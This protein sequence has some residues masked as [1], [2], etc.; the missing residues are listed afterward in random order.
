VS[1]WKKRK[2]PQRPLSGQ[3]N[4][5]EDPWT[6]HHEKVYVTL[7]VTLAGNVYSQKFINEFLRQ[8]Q[9]QKPRNQETTECTTV[10]LYIRGTSERI[11]RIG[12]IIRKQHADNEICEGAKSRRLRPK[13]ETKET[14]DLK[15][16]CRC[17][18]LDRLE[19]RLKPESPTTKIEKYR[20]SKQRGTWIR[21]QWTMT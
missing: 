1:A 20:S 9:K 18:R 13:T 21:G 16:S 3:L 15:H 11:C 7:R 19:V 8:S 14:K 2:K 12:K 10:T 17:E 4:V 6:I 5:E